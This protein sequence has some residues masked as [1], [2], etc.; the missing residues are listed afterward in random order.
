MKEILGEEDKMDVLNE[1]LQGLTG[2]LSHISEKVVEQGQVVDRIDFNTKVTLN[3]TKKANKVCL[4]FLEY[5]LYVIKDFTIKSF[6]STKLEFILS[7]YIF[8]Y[9]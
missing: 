2:M 8:I 5:V 7:T 4:K 3:I 6:K 9:F 1:S